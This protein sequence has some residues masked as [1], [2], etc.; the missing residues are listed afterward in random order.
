MHHVPTLLLASLASIAEA[1]PQSLDGLFLVLVNQ[2]HHVPTL[3]LTSSTTVAKA[4]LRGLDGLFLVSVNRN[5]ETIHAVGPE[6]VLQEGGSIACQGGSSGKLGLDRLTL[7]VWR[8]L[9]SFKKAR[10]LERT[11][12]LEDR[13]GAAH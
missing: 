8:G 13:P 5:G 6:F 12:L 9:S 3:L 10:H 4:G 2:Y 11:I 7:W 1:G